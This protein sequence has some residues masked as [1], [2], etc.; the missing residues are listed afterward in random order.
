MCFIILSHYSLFG[1]SSV[2]NIHTIFYEPFG[3]MGA[4]IFV[5]LSGY[6]LCMQEFNLSKNIF[7]ITKIWGKT[8]AYSWIILILFIIFK[9]TN[10]GIKSALTA[11]F[12]VLFNEYWFIT[13]FIF[14]MML[15]PILNRLIKQLRRRNLLIVI[16][17]LLFISGVQPLISAF[18]PFGAIL[19]V[20]IMITS[21]LFAGYTRI[22][23]VRYKSITLLV[24]FIISFTLQY[25]LR[26]FFNTNIFTYGILPFLCAGSIF[27]MITRSKSYYNS[28]IN[29]FAASVF[30]AYLITSHPLVNSVL[31]SKW[32]NTANISYPILL[33]PVIVL[34]LLVITVLI[35]QLYIFVEKHYLNNKF[36]LISN[37]ITHYFEN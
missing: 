17:V 13:S 6:F 8:I 34:A 9:W 24:L 18:S 25:V 7:R 11:L 2:T 30:A 5:M 16:F 12:P 20:G 37:K 29:W 36:V 3:E 14:L 23:K 33:G 21:Y 19:N 27:I 22:Y 31:W 10:I 4:D 1:N 28:I 26:Y 32:V 35:D 15:V